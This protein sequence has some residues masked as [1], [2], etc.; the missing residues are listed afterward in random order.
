MYEQEV[1]EMQKKVVEI[2]KRPSA[3]PNEKVNQ[4]MELRKE[5]EELLTE[6]KLEYWGLAAMIY[7][8]VGDIWKKVGKPVDAEKAYKEMAKFSDKMY[9]TDKEK[10]DYRQGISHYKLASFYRIGLGCH[11]LSPKPKQLSELQKKVFGLTEGLYINTII[12][13]GDKAKKGAL[14]YVELHS[15]VMS[16]L[17]VMY[18]CIGNYKKAADVALN[19]IK[20]DK[21]IYDQ[22]D[23]KV[24]GMRLASRMNVLAAI[25]S[26]TKET[27][28]SAETIEDAIFVL[29][30][31]EEEEPV[32]AGI[33]LARNYLN[34]GGCY[35][36]IEA[37]KE[38]A[39]EML[40]KGLDKALT[41]NTKANDRLLDDVL[42]AYML[43]GD[44]YKVCKNAQKAKEHYR[45]AL[46]NAQTLQEKT[47]H[48][49]YKPIIERLEK[50]LNSGLS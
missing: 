39:E 34:L 30:R 20:T 10:Y 46:S 50:L 3:N 32:S 49:K 23:D 8:A 14:R 11:V 2:M 28:K 12:C 37:E 45:F 42:L 27:Q 1:L 21:S 44:H 22:V 29:E 47:K 6:E 19:G 48:E 4:F 16:E 43:V 7:E 9:Q 18:A 35:R 26:Y 41:V 31:H 33:M 40:L 5:A 38:N 24:H 13:I 25:Y 15:T 36:G 17:A